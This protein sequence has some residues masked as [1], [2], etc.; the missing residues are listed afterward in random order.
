MTY[1]LLLNATLDVR[2]LL[3]N[4]PP[5]LGRGVCPATTN[6]GGVC[7]LRLESPQVEQRSSERRRKKERKRERERE[8]EKEGRP[9]APN[10]L[11]I[12]DR[13]FLKWD[14]KSIN[15]K[16]RWQSG[17]QYNEKLPFIKTLETR[18][19]D[20]DCGKAAPHRSLTK[21]S[22]PIGDERLPINRNK[23]GTDFTDG[24]AREG[25]SQQ[26]TSRAASENGKNDGLA[27]L[28]RGGV[29]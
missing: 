1:D 25:A 12:W 11:K 8:E 21:D 20:T 24:K 3:E 27:C 19:P 18:R 26:R 7:P 10:R 23:I 15:H 13:R 17:Q 22:H 16:T 9:T 6:Q 28:K 5:M 14:A 29:F 4:Q 2:R